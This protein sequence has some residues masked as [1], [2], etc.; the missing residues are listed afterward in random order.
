M[1]SSGINR[2]WQ[3]T[4]IYSIGHGN[5]SWTS[6]VE[7]LNKHNGKFLV[8]VRSFPISKFNPDFNRENLEISCNKYGIK[9]I[10]M[11]DSLGGKPKGKHLYDKDG[12]A[13]YTI[14]EK[15]KKY[16]FSISRLQIAASL[17]DNTFVM[18]SELCPSQCHRS[19]LIGKTLEELGLH[20]IH[21]DKTGGILSQSEVINLITNG[22]DDLFGNS[23]SISKS[24]GSYA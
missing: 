10:Y 9:Y 2:I 17:D 19:K 21:I 18:C 8:D 15:E 22:Q 20:P 1:T 11:G 23:P 24:R 4:M 16:L 14:M 3:L 7:L 5:R 12:R 13:N 6:F